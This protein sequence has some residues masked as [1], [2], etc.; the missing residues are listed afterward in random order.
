MSERIGGPTATRRRLL[1]AAGAGVA[2]AAAL[3]GVSTAGNQDDG[4]QVDVLWSLF[5]LDSRNTGYQPGD[6]GPAESVGARWGHLDGG[7]YTTTPVVTNGTVIAADEGDGVV[8]AVDRSDGT[9]IWRTDVELGSS[10]LAVQDG[11]VFVP[12]QNDGSQLKALAATDGSEQ[13]DVNLRH[14]A[15]AVVPSDDAVYVAS[16]GGVYGVSRLSNEIDWHVDTMTLADTSVAVV[17]DK[18]YAADSRHGNTTRLSTADGSRNWT[19]YLDGA[20][21]DAPTVTEDHVLVP[22]D[23]HLVALDEG[24][25]RENWRYE[26]AVRG[27]VAVADG[28]VYA[29]TADGDAFALALADGSE[30]WRVTGVPGS[31]PPVVVGNRLYLAGTDGT[32]AALRLADG[33]TIWSTTLDAGLG[34]NPAVV[35][36]ELYLGDDAG[37]LA[38]LA[39]GA[40]GGFEEP[41]GTPPP[42]DDGTAT[43]DDTSTTEDPSTP[44]TRTDTG[45][46]TPGSDPGGSSDVE[47][48][49]TSTPIFSTDT[50]APDDGGIDL[51]LLSGGVAAVLALLGGGLWWRRQ[52]QDDYDKLG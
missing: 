47:S 50:P 20:A 29:T 42:T 37:R 40:S 52:Q 25:G 16:V 2:G 13:W 32:L 23:D 19:N 9:E 22:L 7:A 3:T 15:N 46:S 30:R 14:S 34:A 26:A 27:S 28:A 11:T 6:Y 33:T 10:R 51:G 1:G 35:G 18:V 21:H 41:T 39:P 12:A 31:N 5:Q 8:R 17:G 44:T 38:A 4:E 49:E 36:G 43:P 45:G 24:T 48:S